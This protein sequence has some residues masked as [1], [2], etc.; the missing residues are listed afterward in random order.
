MKMKLA[1]TLAV[2]AAAG[3]AFVGPLAGSATAA[4]PGA[5]FPTHQDR[6]WGGWN[7]PGWHDPADPFRNDWHCDRHGAWHDDEHDGWG[8][9]DGRCRPW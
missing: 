2:V 1:S 9:W 3:A 8:H 5:Q 7:R 4:V 6:D